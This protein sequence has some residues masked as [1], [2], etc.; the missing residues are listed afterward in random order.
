M[1][2]E[3]ES[4]TPVGASTPPP[5]TD[6]LPD[7]VTNEMLQ[8]CKRLGDPQLSQVFQY[9]PTTVIK[10]VHPASAAVAEAA[11]M[12]LTHERTSVPVPRVL[13]TV[14]PS[15]GENGYGLIFME[16]IEGGSLQDAW[17]SYADEEK[18]RTLAQL[19]AHLQELRRVEGD[20]IGPVDGSI[21]NDQLFANAVGDY[22]PYRDEEAF[23]AG[24]AEALRSCEANSFTEAVIN[25]VNA[26][27]GS[28]RAVLT[29]GDL[30][31]R[32]ILVRDGNVV[33]LVDWE[34]SGFYPEYWEYA[35]AHFFADYD[36][37]WMEDRAV[38][39]IL[40]PYPLELAALLHT[41]GI[42]MY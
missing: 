34:M 31:P 29:H 41:R 30:V 14:M 28:G 3:I 20:L 39:E 17:P 32:N 6:A 33:G 24:M 26:M 18:A 40:T 5:T 8:Q 2:P 35:K 12:R 19:R 10:R 11:A 23:R 15:D 16:Y 27:P 38:D 9:N 37:S 36:H 13:K 21:C 25:M 42:F 1:D 22:G 4:K 7:L